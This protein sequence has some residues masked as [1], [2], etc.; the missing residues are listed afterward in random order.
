MPIHDFKFMPAACPRTLRPVESKL[1]ECRSSPASRQMAGAS[2]EP[3]SRHCVL[4]F[5]HKSGWC[6]H[7]SGISGARVHPTPASIR[8]H[9]REEKVRGICEDRRAARPKES[10]RAE[11]VL[12]AAAWLRVMS[13]GFRRQGGPCFPS[14][15]TVRAVGSAVVAALAAGS[16]AV[17]ELAA[18]AA[19]ALDVE[20][21]LAAGVEAESCVLA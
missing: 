3:R 18:G 14:R 5:I 7:G 19:A 8:L 9:Q 20:A 21:A 15:S 2:G 16:A 13:L 1:P 10:R 11:E 6:R 17:V 12:H 4:I